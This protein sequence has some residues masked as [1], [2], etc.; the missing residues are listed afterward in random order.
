MAIGPSR[1]GRAPTPQMDRWPPAPGP[2][3]LWRLL[4]FPWGC[5]KRASGFLSWAERRG[6]WSP[7]NPS[8]PQALARWPPE[9]PRLLQVGAVKATGQAPTSM[10]RT[11][12]EGPRDG[13]SAGR[14]G[15]HPRAGGRV[16]PSYRGSHGGSEQGELFTRAQD[17]DAEAPGPDPSS[18]FQTRTSWCHKDNT[19]QPSTG[20]RDSLQ[21][22]LPPLG[23]R[24]RWES[25]PD[26]ALL[27]P[28]SSLGCW[29]GRGRPVLEGP[30]WEGGALY[31]AAAR[32][33]ECQ[34]GLVLWEGQGSMGKSVS[35]GPGCPSVVLSH[36]PRPPGQRKGDDCVESAWWNIC[37]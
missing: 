7:P 28:G 1:R 29:A 34:P 26:Q 10:R 24:A 30:S 25:W 6:T 2:R 27:H 5:F 37:A 35:A 13:R 11:H 14:S 21:H 31:H 32:P 12:K 23:L 8:T 4:W 3:R 16:T 36:P 33:P 17:S 15:G 20:P 18:E 9:G 22:S 19:W